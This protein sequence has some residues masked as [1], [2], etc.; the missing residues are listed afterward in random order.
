RALL[1]LYVLE[2]L[3]QS[4]NISLEEG[5]LAA[6]V[7]KTYE[8]SELK[9]NTELVML[10]KLGVTTCFIADAEHILFE[11]TVKVVERVALAAASEELKTK[12]MQEDHQWK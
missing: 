6:G 11:P 10:R 5:K 7:L 9:A 1:S 3:L 12:W 4:G 8:A 2:G